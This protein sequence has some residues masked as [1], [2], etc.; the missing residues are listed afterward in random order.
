MDYNKKIDDIIRKAIEDKDTPFEAQHWQQFEQQL[1]ASD[2]T[3]GNTKEVDA[4]DGALAQGLSALDSEIPSDWSTFENLLDTD[5]VESPF[6]DAIV[7]GLTAATAV[8]SPDWSAFTDILSEAEANDLTADNNIVDQKAQENLENYEAPYNP[9]NWILMREKLAE[10]FSLR[11]RLIRYKVAEISLMLLAIFT[12]FN[13]LPKNELGKLKVIE[14]VKER[15]IKKTD[16]PTAKKEVALKLPTIKEKGTNEFVPPLEI[17][18]LPTGNTTNYIAVGKPVY[19]IAEAPTSNFSSFST[20]IPPAITEKAEEAQLEANAMSIPPVEDKKGLFSWLNKEKSKKDKKKEET[21]QELINPGSILLASLST[22]QA[23]AVVSSQ[24]EKDLTPSKPKINNKAVRLGMFTS[25]DLFGVYSP[26]DRFFN[27]R[28]DVVYS[29][30]AGG[31]IMI[32]FQRART[33]I[34]VG[35]AYMPK[36]FTPNLSDEIYGSFFTAYVSEE[37]ESI[38]L[39]VLHIPFELRYDF[40]QKSKWRVYGMAGMSANVVLNTVYRIDEKASVYARAMPS[41]EEMEREEKS[42][43]YAKTF[44]NGAA[45]G[46]NFRDNTFLSVQL[47]FGFERFISQRWSIFFED[48][49]QQQFSRNPIGPNENSFRT[50]SLRIG[51]K[52]TMFGK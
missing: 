23:E 1:D 22:K 6:D 50:M 21:A 39:D 32:D 24:K 47:G 38:Q 19:V 40:I 42:N 34:L 9:E 51:A 11:R 46:G 26:Y 30:N 2:L 12:L 15:L 49:Y 29:S 27:Y 20:I 14:K 16:K 4:F 35:G 52:A 17:T 10:E 7:A 48:S 33:H 31:G 18:L 43:I 36:Y 41:A 28:P 3:D 8:T 45:E 13:Y 37:F 5:Q 44:L 25:L